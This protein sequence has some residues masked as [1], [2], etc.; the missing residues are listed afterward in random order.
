M[1]CT[2]DYCKQKTRYIYFGRSLEESRAFQCLLYAV[3]ALLSLRACVQAA[4]PPFPPFPP[5][6]SLSL[7][8]HSF[9]SP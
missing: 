8:S 6:F 4:L 5:S 3:P 9:F 7:S 1:T 2:G